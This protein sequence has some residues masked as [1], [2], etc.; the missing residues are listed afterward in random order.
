[1][2]AQAARTTSD[3]LRN[4]RSL[5]A[6][7]AEALPAIADPRDRA[8]LEAIC[9]AVLRHRRR[10]EFVLSTWMDR[11]LR[12][13]DAEV[14]ALL[15]C[16]LA[17]LDALKLAPHAALAAT[18][19]AARVLG[20]TQ[21]VGL[22]NALLRR[23]VRE[24][25]PVSDDLA[26]T[27]S[28]PDWLVAALQRDWPEDWQAVL[29]ANN[30][31]PPLWLAVNPRLGTREDYLALLVADGLGAD[32]PAAPALALLL[33]APAVPERL[34]GWRAGRVWVQDGAAQLA[35]EALDAG[36]AMRVLDACAAPGGKC[37]QLAARADVAAGGEVVAVDID[38]R[39]LRRVGENLDRL[40]LASHAVQLVVGDATR[41]SEWHDGNAFD[42]I[43]LD[44]PCTATGIV[45]RQPD[46]KWHR[47][48]DDVATLAGLQS[49]LLDALWA[50]LRP[51]GR[52]LYSTCSVLPAENAEQVA[53]FLARTPDA[54]ALPLDARFG[55]VAGDGRQRLP[56]EDGMDGFFYA[57]LARAD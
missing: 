30:T 21:M 25:W 6:A 9:F 50:L 8:L 48:A 36:P 46:I 55:R 29:E 53:G 35:V 54:R 13:R 17:Q 2:R 16:G 42:A 18:A 3:V 33:D 43:L 32:A 38:A 31:P 10:Y 4:G 34:P 40:Q 26:V 28:H 27:S 20:R 5:K 45:R 24:P 19:E 14:H 37:A 11:G 7:L 39:R 23:A 22:V 51:G 15:L 52:L 44:A 47:R 12:G 1:L 57:L 49:A 41:P 56:G